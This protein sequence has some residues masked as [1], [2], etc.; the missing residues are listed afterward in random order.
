MT[1]Q[2]ITLPIN[3]IDLHITRTREPHLSEHRST[4]LLAIHGRTGSGLL[5]RAFLEIDMS[6]RS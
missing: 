4:F 2:S 6:E 5:L 3:G 1:W